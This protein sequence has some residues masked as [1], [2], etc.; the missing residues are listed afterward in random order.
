MME[1]RGY[2]AAVEFDDSSNVLHGRVINSGAYP[3]A[4]F[5][6]TDT[7]QLRREFH[8]SIDEYLA[9]CEED[10]VEPKR[11]FSGKLNVRLGSEL[12][13]AVAAAAA[14]RGMSIN[15][16]IVGV[17]REGTNAPYRTTRE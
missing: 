1:Y 13:A 11:P 2:L 14:A 10:G 17:V 8:R 9:W 4:T 6:A 5:E 16:W 3:I 15:S 12:H 7:A